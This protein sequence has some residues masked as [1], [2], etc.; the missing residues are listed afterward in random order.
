MS[1]CAIAGCDKAARS[2]GWCR[3]H[4]YRW[5]RHGDPLVTKRPGPDHHFTAALSIGR[6]SADGIT[7]HLL[8]GGPGRSHRGYGHVN[9][10]RGDYILAHRYAYERW[11]GPIPDGYV[12]DHRPDCPKVCVNPAHL[13]V[14]TPS[15]H[16]RLGWKRGELRGR[17]GHV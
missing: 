5:Y 2:R 13:Q 4:Y 8:Y 14:L 6:L 11:V 7:R 10:G 15:D 17:Y 1:T 3:Q 12:V 9:V 16:S